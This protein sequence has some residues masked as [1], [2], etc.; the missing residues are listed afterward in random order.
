MITSA[1]RDVTDRTQREDAR[2]RAGA[3]EAQEHERLRIA[4][5]LHDQLSQA[6]TGITLG[7]GRIEAAERLEAAQE[8]AESLRGE[9][10]QALKD[11]RQVAMQLRPD[12]L[13]ELSLDGACERLVQDQQRTDPQTEIAF[14]GTPPTHQLE[15]EAELAVYRIVQEALANAARHADAELIEVELGEEGSNFCARVRDDGR[16]FGAEESAAGLGLGGMRE[17]ADLA[18]GELAIHSTPGRGTEVTLR[19]PSRPG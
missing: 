13:D 8:E 7:L 16:G 6:L 17:R 11:L 12:S 19:V 1:I 10:R 15:P 14:R 2:R 18:D 3:I 5:E 4:R 9:V